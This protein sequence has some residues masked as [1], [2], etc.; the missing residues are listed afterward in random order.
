P[1]LCGLLNSKDEV[2]F[3][4][5]ASIDTRVVV[6]T[7]FRTTPWA[8]LFARMRRIP[9]VSFVQGYEFLFDNG[10]VRDKVEQSYWLPDSVVTTSSWVE[11]GVRLRTPAKSVSV[12][13]LGVEHY[14]F[15]PPSELAARGKIRIAMFLRR[16]PDKGQAVLL[17]V[18]DQLLPYRDEL[19]AT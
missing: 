5:D 9:L 3:L 17:E 19:S 2:S 11:G 6:A 15:F 4:A 13:P 1:I 14:Q 10:R 18:L 7:L 12:L 16:E 8:F